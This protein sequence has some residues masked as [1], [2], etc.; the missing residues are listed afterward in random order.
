MVLGFSWFRMN[1]R[2]SHNVSV[3]KSWGLL[4]ENL[5]QSICIFLCCKWR[6]T[7]CLV[8][9]MGFNSLDSNCRCNCDDVIIGLHSYMESVRLVLSSGGLMNLISLDSVW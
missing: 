6:A 9:H 7:P 8:V 4:W 5:F 2:A 1:C 3:L